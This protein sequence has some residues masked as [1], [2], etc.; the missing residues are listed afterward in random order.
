MAGTTGLEPAASAVTGLDMENQALTGSMKE[1]EVLKT[2][3]GRLLFLRMNLGNSE[4][5]FRTDWHRRSNVTPGIPKLEA[6]SQ[7]WIRRFGVSCRVEK[8]ENVS[9]L[10]LLAQQA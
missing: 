4:T 9:R 10:A 2:H 5:K 7:G 6:A 8:P 1:R 3:K